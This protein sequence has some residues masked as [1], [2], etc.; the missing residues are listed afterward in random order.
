[1]T[2]VFWLPDLLFDIFRPRREEGLYG[3]CFGCLCGWLSSL[4]QLVRSDALAYVNLASLPYCNSSRFCDL[5]CRNSSMFHSSYSVS[6]VYFILTQF[7]R[8]GAHMWLGA[9]LVALGWF[10][11]GNAYTLLTAGLIFSVGLFL[12]TYF[13][14][15]H[16][17]AAEALSI[18][19]LTE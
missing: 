15:L 6:R 9:L 19:F 8:L 3:R 16:A 13:V 18:T 14:S 17:D 2:A 10:Y 1:M 12:L 5:L 4:F 11:R 7:Y